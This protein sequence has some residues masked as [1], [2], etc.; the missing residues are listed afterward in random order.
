MTKN[1]DAKKYRLIKEIMNIN[2]EYLL[3]QIDDNIKKA[4]Q[5]KVAIWDEVIQPTKQTISIEEMIEEQN[6]TPIQ[7]EEFFELAKQMNIEE[8]IEELLEQLH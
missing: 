3:D 4:L 6:Y 1:L 7:A 2:E 8:S 5:K